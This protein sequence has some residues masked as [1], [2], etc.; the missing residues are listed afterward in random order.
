MDLTDLDY[1]LDINGLSRH[2][3]T[4]VELNE[5]NPGLGITAEDVNNKVVKALMAG[6]YKNSFE[7]PSLYAGG[8]LARRFGNDY[9]ADLGVFGG[10]ATGYGDTPQ[11]TKDG[12]MYEWDYKDVNPMGGLMMNLGK[13]DLGRIGIKYL[14]TKEGV[15]MMNLGIPIR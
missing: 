4:P 3:N 5:T 1:Y 15:I 9:Y 7:N 14:P 12:T 8:S 11:I 10:L 6:F 13:K 2:I